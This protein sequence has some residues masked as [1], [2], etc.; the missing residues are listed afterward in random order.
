MTLAPSHA[1][2]SPVGA[3]S[4]AGALGS[5]ALVVGLIFALG[6]VAQRLRGLR[7]ARGAGD[8]QMLGGV[9]VGNKERVVVLR[10]G[11]DHLV[12]GVA[13]GSVNLLH[14][15]AG[16]AAHGAFTA[17]AAPQAPVPFADKLRDLLRKQ[18]TA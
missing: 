13:P 11:E 7:A 10:V 12:V 9:A 17:E 15:Y 18:E 14:R 2:V 5:L 16:V 4:V 3:G 6:W 8:L 1:P